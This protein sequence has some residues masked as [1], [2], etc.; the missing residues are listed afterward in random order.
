[1]ALPSSGPLSLGDI[2]TYLGNTTLYSLHDMSVQVGFTDP[3]AVSEFYGYSTPVTVSITLCDYIS[4]D[5]SG[6][7]TLSATSDANVDTAVTVYWTWSGDLGST[8]YGITTISS[9]TSYGVG[10]EF[11][12]VAG[13]NNV[14]ISAYVSP[15]SFGTQS[16]DV[17][18][19]YSCY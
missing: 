6:I 2:G 1:M 19:P 13:E 12:A 10:T 9:G 18:P 17:G 5:G 3:D 16:Y 15:T 4:A 11:G 8:I 7:V 14:S